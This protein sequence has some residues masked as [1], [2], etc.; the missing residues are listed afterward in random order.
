MEKTHHN[1]QQKA[2]DSAQQHDSYAMRRAGLALDR[3]VAAKS[4]DDRIRSRRWVL[5]WSGIVRG[6]PL[7]GHPDETLRS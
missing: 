5:A 3:L 2:R 4:E 6:R 1:T 7:V